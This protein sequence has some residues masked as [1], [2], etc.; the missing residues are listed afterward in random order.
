[1][2]VKPS[3]SGILVGHIPIGTE[4]V[5]DKIS[6]QPNFPIVLKDKIIHMILSHHGKLEYGAVVEPKLPEAATLHQAD[7][8]GSKITQYIRAKK[9]AT[10][11]GFQSGWNK[12]IG[13]VFLE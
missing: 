8:M 2:H 13:S 1:M 12:Y 11:D 6:K 4:M 9:D 10:T 5:R 3:K 7:M